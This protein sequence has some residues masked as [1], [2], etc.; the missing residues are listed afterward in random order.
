MVG[1]LEHANFSNMKEQ[2]RS[3]YQDTLGPIMSQ[4]SQAFNL[5]LAADLG[6]PES[7]YFEFNIKEKLRGSFEEEAAAIQTAVGAPHM[8]RNE[9]RARQNLP[10]IEGGDDLVTPLNVLVGGQASPTDSGTQNVRRRTASRPSAVKELEGEPAD[11]ADS[12]RE[13]LVAFFGRQ[14]AAVL[15]RL[16]ALDDPNLQAV[17]QRDRWDR[18]LTR[19]LYDAAVEAA[20]TAGA[21][22]AVQLEAEPVDITTADGFGDAL[23]ASS[24]SMASEINDWTERKL[25]EAL[26]DDD[27]SGSARELFA[28]LVG[29]R[30]AIY[31]TSRTNTVWNFARGVAGK[32]VG[33]TE[34]RWRTTSSNPRRSHKAMDGETVPIGERFSNG[35]MWPGDPSLDVDERA[36]CNCTFDVLKENP[37]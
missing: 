13:V 24:E 3:T 14:Q 32:T 12:L 31:A 17:W 22:V 1:I 35:A 30:A 21:Q 9:A 7:A 8:T 37:S 19:D 5:Q 28:G 2:H 33:A 27:P 36:G 4:L 20:K 25:T 10:A 29:V 23:A 6:L 11:E 15:A 16:G 34:K 18:E 26:A